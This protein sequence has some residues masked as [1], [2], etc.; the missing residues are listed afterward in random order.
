[1]YMYRYVFGTGYVIKFVM[2]ACLLHHKG[3]YLYGYIDG[4]ELHVPA[5]M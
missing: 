5:A 2:F 3:I 1:M 4:F